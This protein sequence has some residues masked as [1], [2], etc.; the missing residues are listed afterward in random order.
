MQRYRATRRRR[1]QE[2]RRTRARRLDSAWEVAR[3]AAA[4]LKED[5]GASRVLL[6]GSVACREP[7]TERSD[8]DLA[9]WGLTPAAHLEAVAR[10]QGMG[11]FSVDLVR[12]ER[13]LSPLREAILKTGVAL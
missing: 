2:A 10:L 7:L 9:V 1:E 5:F 12:M 6:F 4:L 11:S 13:C 3:G 8:I